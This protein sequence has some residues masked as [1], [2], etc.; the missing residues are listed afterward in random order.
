MREKSLQ[1]ACSRSLSCSVSCRVFCADAAAVVRTVA[2]R[3]PIIT[4]RWFHFDN[5]CTAGKK[6][7]A[8]GI[9]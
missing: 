3:L 8:P 1:N 5:A 7:F 4:P 9:G 2:E 6:F